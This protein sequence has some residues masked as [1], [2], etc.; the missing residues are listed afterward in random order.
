MLIKKMNIVRV[1][2]FTNVGFL[3]N[4][5]SIY[6]W[7]YLRLKNTPQVLFAIEKYRNYGA[8]VITTAQPRSP[9][10][11]FKFRAGSNPA[12]GV[13]KICDDEYFWQG[14]R[15]EIKRKTFH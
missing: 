12:H 2:I 15:R 7:K 13:S 8:M 6:F 9:N 5:A 4:L 10:P 14:S 11:E 3:R 1:F